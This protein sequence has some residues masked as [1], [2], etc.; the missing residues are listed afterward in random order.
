MVVYRAVLLRNLDVAAEKALARH[1][2]DV[3]ALA[4]DIECQDGIGLVPLTQTT[5]RSRRR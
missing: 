5:P 3:P 2:I 4:G 1:G